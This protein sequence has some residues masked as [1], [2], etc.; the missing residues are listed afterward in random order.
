MKKN[1]LQV[2][3]QK[4]VERL[5]PQWKCSSLK[6]SKKRSCRKVTSVR[7]IHHCRLVE[8]VKM[9]VIDVFRRCSCRSALAESW[10]L[11]LSFFCRW[12]FCSNQQSITCLRELKKNYIITGCIKWC[13]IMWGKIACCKETVDHFSKCENAWSPESIYKGCLSLLV[14]STLLRRDRVG[15]PSATIL[16]RCRELTFSDFILV[17]AKKFEIKNRYAQEPI[18]NDYRRR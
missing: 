8:K 2:S 18:Q 5:V 14:R 6:L 1:F 9:L 10:N 13:R 3:H 12:S 16:A 17:K 4:D 15:R 7:W 11:Q